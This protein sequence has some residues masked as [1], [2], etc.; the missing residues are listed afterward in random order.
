M[1]SFRIGRR[2]SIVTSI[3]LLSLSATACL[4]GTGPDE[5]EEP[6]I[7]GVS[8]A[9]ATGSTASGAA[10]VTQSGQTGT[11]T[12]RA[13]TANTLTVR[14]LDLTGQDEAVVAE[15]SDEFE[16]RVL[17]GTNV[18]A[19]G[20]GAYP[21]SI[22]VTPTQVGQLSYTVQVYATEHGHVELTRPLLVTVVAQ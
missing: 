15:H 14:V 3:A 6:E 2:A 4:D 17:L 5:H 13:N 21:Y 7:A 22:S 12:L 9:A 11:L 8:V 1:S 19:T 10:T 18:I 16:I 20:T